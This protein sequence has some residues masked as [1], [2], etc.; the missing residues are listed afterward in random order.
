M[1]P[2]EDYFV[3]NIWIADCISQQEVEHPI[4]QQILFV[5]TDR[6]NNIKCHQNKY[7][8]MPCSAAVPLVRILTNMI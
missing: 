5:L 4:G 2:A 1:K 7:T 8:L 3:K 6:A